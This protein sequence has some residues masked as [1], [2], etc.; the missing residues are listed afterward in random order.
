MKISKVCDLLAAELLLE[1]LT[2]SLQMFPR[3][4]GAG[5]ASAPCHIATASGNKVSPFNKISISDRQ[6][7]LSVCRIYLNDEKEKP[8]WNFCV[9]LKDYRYTPEN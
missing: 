4:T 7:A 3:A 6:G 8:K 5:T 9:F 2:C 1:S